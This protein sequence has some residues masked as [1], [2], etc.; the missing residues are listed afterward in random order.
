MPSCGR[1]YIRARNLYVY[2]YTDVNC[3]VSIIFLSFL[4]TQYETRQSE[5]LLAVVR[6]KVAAVINEVDKPKG[7]AWKETKL[8]TMNFISL[9]KLNY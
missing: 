8:P 2:M 6:N 9:M 7:Q 3:E 4:G 5:V 1:R